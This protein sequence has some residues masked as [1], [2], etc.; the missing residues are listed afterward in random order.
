M[1]VTILKRT[2]GDILPSYDVTVTGTDITGFTIQ[3][4]VQKPDGTTVF[5]RTA[6]IVDGPNGLARFTFTASNFDVNG[7]YK[8]EIEITDIGSNNETFGDIVIK[9]RPQFA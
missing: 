4:H 9:V 6:V 8:A 5:T 2:V 1:A 3:M 7:N